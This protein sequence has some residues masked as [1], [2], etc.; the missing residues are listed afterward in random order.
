M[1]IAKPCCLMRLL[2]LLYLEKN[3]VTTSLEYAH[4]R[5][6]RLTDCS[7]DLRKREIIFGLEYIQRGFKT[8]P[9][10]VLHEH[11]WGKTI[12]PQYLRVPRN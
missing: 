4:R 2:P 11:S 1:K 8:V 5:R 9:H 10:K 7:Q 12:D 6:L 3:Y